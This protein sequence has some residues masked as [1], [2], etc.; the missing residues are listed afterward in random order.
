MQEIEKIPRNCEK[1]EYF[2]IECNKIVW[3]QN[4]ICLQFKDAIKLIEVKRSQVLLEIT[5]SD[6][7]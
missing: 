2:R 6:K 3:F 4:I 5:E 1:F 7:Q